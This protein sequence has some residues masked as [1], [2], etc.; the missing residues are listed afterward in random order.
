MNNEI[1]T[2]HYKFYQVKKV[3]RRYHGF[4]DLESYE[5]IHKEKIN[6]NRY[7]IA[8]E[9]QINL[10]YSTIHEVLDYL[11][12][13]FNIEHPKDFD[14]YSMSVGD[15]IEI[16]EIFYYCDSF[17]WKE[18]QVE[19]KKPKVA[20]EE[21]LLF[22]HGDT[23]DNLTKRKK[24]MVKNENLVL[25]YISDLS[26]DFAQFCWEEGYEPQKVYFIKNKTND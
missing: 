4:L 10:S 13:I 14:G 15:I 24:L 25:K 19:T 21:Y 18:I 9:K 2:I 6:L 5:S 26:K 16:N 1:K 11:F 12:R 20:I 7:L 23:L 3:F 17:G 8:Y 22:E